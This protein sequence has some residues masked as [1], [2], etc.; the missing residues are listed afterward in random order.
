MDEKVHSEFDEV[1]LIKNSTKCFGTIIEE[2]SRISNEVQA[3]I[4]SN[5]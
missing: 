5:R 1:S 2:D 3:A 4:W